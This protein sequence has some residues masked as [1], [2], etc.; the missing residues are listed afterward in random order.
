VSATPKGADA[1]CRKADHRPIEVAALEGFEIMASMIC[2][3]YPFAQLAAW[4]TIAAGFCILVALLL[5]QPATAQVGARLAPEPP[6]ALLKSAPAPTAGPHDRVRTLGLRAGLQAERGI[7]TEVFYDFAIRY[8]DGKLYNP[9]TGAYDEVR[10]RS[11]V[12]DVASPT[13]PFVAPR[14]DIWPGETFRLTLKNQLPADDP[15][16]SGPTND[17]NIPHCFNNTNMHTHGLWV[18]PVGNGDNVLL[19]VNPGIDFQYEYNIPSDHPSGTF[20]YH[21]HLH[22]STALQVSSGMAGPLIVHGDRAPNR[23]EDG[24]IKPGDIDT[25]LKT[26]EGQPFRERV[27]LL[28]QIPY[29]CRDGNG[30]IKTN[31]DETWRCDSG[32]V[33][34]IEGYDQLRPG[35]WDASGRYTSINGEVVPTLAA[36][37]AGAVERWRIIHAGV[38]DTIKLRL[39][40]LEPSAVEVAYRAVT[41]DAKES[42][43]D[44]NCTGEPL[45]A[46]GLA[47]DG[48]T[49]RALNERTDTIMQPGYREDLLVVFPEPGTYC[50]IDGELEPVETVNN[51]GY[52]RELLGYIEVE[53]A[54]APGADTSSVDTVIDAL[55]ASAQANLPDDVSGEIITAL[56]DGMRLSAFVAHPDVAEA[57]VTG[58]QT[59]GFRIF[60]ASISPEPPRIQ[61][62]IGQLGQDLAG[63]LTLRKSAPYDPQRIDRTLLLGG[64]DE[65]T[66]TSFFA[67][68]PF[69][70]HVNPFQI[71][72]VLNADGVDVSGPGDPNASQYANLKGMWKDT[73]F[74]EQSHI[75]KLRTR[76]Q[77]Y[78]GEYVLHCHILDHEDQGMMQNVRIAIPDGRGGVTAAHH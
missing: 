68:H 48:L 45:A 59:L 43:V 72:E 4:L 58:K 17:S 69:H 8:T 2:S 14:V 23:R 19:T 77:R 44:Q 24:S 70:I 56:Q 32:D 76:Y 18:S 11:Y 39:R 60:N 35:S 27:L 10:L 9:A 42:F 62:E 37:Q 64:V 74:V 66:L 78:I 75:I 38:R 50:I 41:T 52:G 26:P 65:W 49:R 40:K 22:G 25:L 13:V 47:A 12:G 73:L 31:P 55:V 53:G 63:N 54:A 33:G 15:S 36:A 20:W 61:F 71:V 6:S 5:T 51:E 30:A 57:E 21:P 46:L 67:G 3:R 16:C 34:T 29:A 1:P 7:G 28:Q